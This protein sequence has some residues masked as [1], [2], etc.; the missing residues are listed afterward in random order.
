MSY[1]I[2]LDNNPN[3]ADIAAVRAGLRQYNLAHVPELAQLPAPEIAIVARDEQGGIIGG[4]VGNGDWGWFFPD[5]VWVDERQR[6]QGLGSRL[7]AALEQAVC[8]QGLTRIYLTTTSFQALP[9]YQKLGYDLWGEL[10]DHPRGYRYYYLK[11]EDL[12]PAN[13]AHNLEVQVPPQPADYQWLDDALLASVARYRPMEM[14]S[15]AVVAREGNE[16]VGGLGGAT[17]WDW[18]DLQLMWVSDRLR[19]AGLGT[20]LLG[21]A[22]AECLRRGIYHVTCDT[23][24]FQAL[25]FYRKHGFEVFGTLPNRP[26]GHT[27]YYLSKDLSV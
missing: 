24:D 3:P 7:M 25:W 17:Y 15:L 9:F 21:M 19:G 26:P 22:E 20:R 4:A 8:D 5:V 6:G 12:Q 13:I 11:K 16:V 1:T 14:Q 27:S 2:L 18:F 23:A 10:P